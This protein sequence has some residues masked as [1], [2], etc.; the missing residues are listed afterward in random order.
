MHFDLENF[1]RPVLSL[2]LANLIIAVLNDLGVSPSQLFEH[3]DFH[4]DR[5]AQQDEF[6]SFNQMFAMIDAGLKLSP[7]P[8]LGLKVGDSETVGTW[9]ALGYAIMSSANEIEAAAIGPKYYQAAPSLMHS[10]TRVENGRQGI[11][12]D[13]IYPV[14]R[15][16]PFCVE[17][18][19]VGIMRVSSEYLQEPM[20]PLEIELSY[21]KP[22]YARKYNQYFD[23]PIHYDRPHNI[24][25]TMPP[26]DRPL[27]TSDSAS[28]AIC[29]QLAE[30]LVSRHR[31]EDDFLLQVRRELLRSPGNMPDMEKVASSMAMSSRTLRRK[32]G[33]LSTSFR[34]LQD[35]VRKNLALDYLENTEMNMDQIAARLGYTETTNFRRAFKHWTGSIPSRFRN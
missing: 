1:D 10:S 16:I 19:I 29:L 12:M 15:L 25:W 28:A 34:K 30:Q 9:G 2:Q 33:S 24:V 5:L 8:W 32:L 17:E 23:C 27:R 14:E 4:E 22:V 26:K 6:L 11:Q 20:Q 7:I 13:P 18:N 3:L 31:G 21:S 35:D